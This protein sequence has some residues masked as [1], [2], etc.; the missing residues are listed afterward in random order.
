MKSISTHVM[1]LLVGIG[2]GIVLSGCASTTIK[3]LSGQDFIKQAGQIEQLNSFHWTSYVGNSPGRAYLEFG[4]PTPFGKGS[5]TTVYW[6]PLS[7][8]PTEIA[9]Q[10]NDGNPPWKPWR[11]QTNMTERTTPPTMP[12]PALCAGE[13]R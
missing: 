4:Y 1:T 3:R 11:P 7:E 9:Q 12:S 6:A 10:L 2:I 13:V 5:R 8:L